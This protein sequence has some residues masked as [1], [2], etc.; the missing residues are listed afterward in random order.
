M[1]SLL[2]G[3]LLLALVLPAPAAAAENSGAE[4]AYQLPLDGP[5]PRTYRV[6]LAIT[7]PTQPGFIFSEFASGVVRTVTAANQG[8]FTEHWNGLDD[9][10]MPLPPGAYAVKG[11]FLPAQEWPVDGQFHSVTPRFVTGASSWLPAPEAAAHAPLPFGGDPC[12]APLTSVAVGPNGHAVFYYGYLENDRNNP[13]FD[14]NQ[15]IG[16]AQFLRSYPSGGAA[17]GD[18]TATDGAIV[19]S[20][21]HEGCPDAVYRA[22]GLPFGTGRAHRDHVFLPAGKVTAMAAYHDDRAG[23]SYL[24]LAQRGRLVSTPTEPVESTADFIDQVTFLDGDNGALLAQRPLRR[25]QALAIHESILYAL[26]LAKS[27]AW[28]IVSVPLAA[29]RPQGPWQKVFTVPTAIHPFDLAV[30]SHAS[31]YLS[32]PAANHVY[33]LDAAGRILTKLGARDAQTPGAYDPATMMSPGKMAVW[34]DPAGR[35]H[36]LVVEQAGPNRVAE[37]SPDGTLLRAFLNYQT[38]ANHGYTLD[39]ANPSELYIAGQQ[40]WLLRFHIDFATRAWKVDAVWP[41]DPVPHQGFDFLGDSHQA[42]LQH[43]RLLRV[44]GR[45]Y[46]ACARSFTV[47]RHDGNRWLLSAAFL[48]RDGKDFAW[49]DANGNGR[50]DPAELTPLP[51]PPGAIVFRY[52]G[53]QFLDDLSLVSPALGGR[54][55]DRLAAEGFDSHGNPIY[56]RWQPLFTDPVFELRTKNVER[57][58]KATEA[59]TA[60]AAVLSSTFY[61]LRSSSSNELDDNF[62]SDWAEADGATADGFF[63]VARGGKSPS[64][65]NGAQDKISRYVP[66][67]R[68]G[69]RLQWRTGRQAFG[70]ARPGEII[71]AMHLHAPINGLLAIIDQSRCGLLL[72]TADGLYV[73]TLFPDGQVTDPATAGLYDLPGEFFA[74]DLIPDQATGTIYALLGKETPMLYAM[75][76]W[77]TT[78]NP[79]HALETLPREITLRAADIAPPPPIALALRGGVGTAPVARFVPA[80]GGAVLDGSMTGWSAAPPIRFQS[81][82]QHTVEIRGLYDPDHLYLRWHARLGAP[83]HPRPLAPLER[84]FTHD[85]RADTL[86]LY[87]QGDPNAAPPA[88][89]NGR[90]GDARLVFGLL[91]DG[92]QLKPALLGLYPSWPAGAAVPASPQTYGTAAGGLVTFAQA[93][94]VP[95]AELHAILDPDQRGFVLT[96]AIPRAAFPGLPPFG[97]DLRTMVDFEATFAGHDKF[98]WANSD[99][100]ANRETYDEPTEARLYPGAWAPLGFAGLGDGI[101]LRDWLV[102]GPFGGPGAEKFKR[103]PAIA[104]GDATPVRRFFDAATYAPERGPVDPRA[105]FRGPSLRGYW[106][107]PR[108]ERWTPATVPDLATRLVLGDGAQM[109]YAATWVHAPAD[110]TL[111]FRFQGQVQ[112]YL[113]WFLN[114]ALVQHG[115]IPG[116][117]PRVAAKALTLRRGWNQILLRAYCT[118]SPPLHAGLILAGPPEKLW[119]LRLSGT[120]P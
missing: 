87:L 33:R 113:A 92:A 46:L 104:G 95:G 29:G 64:A 27:G 3:A 79:V 108:E 6:T 14:L 88:N 4:I 115:E 66:D 26:H 61:A 17:G 25:P 42:Q 74:G 40:N 102:V 32:D 2:R 41:I 107:D 34:T 103:D 10:F 1:I 71:G 53:E 98:W 56:K 78:V 5:L 48:H 81:D 118:G 9:N 36:L 38:K 96:A 73:D 85:R 111:E 13:V 20:L 54:S 18:V 51:S 93:G 86:S 35:D 21:A 89:A 97:P 39:P 69:Y 77:T 75:D 80:L 106:P 60:D 76:G 59:T 11:I 105:L 47:Y 91:R 94:P 117:E 65:N 24:C 31:F 8:R 72:Y 55:V 68:G 28:E 63:V 114:G 67:G 82:A 120:L 37:W 49:H 45:D 44:N 58:T 19:W 52:H 100:T 90:P 22:D 109:W 110:T 116:P 112:A 83:F 12:D 99:G 16:P 15:P 119:P 7:D 50:I 84:I 62:S 101:L 57:R 70:P 43:P 30:D 23:K